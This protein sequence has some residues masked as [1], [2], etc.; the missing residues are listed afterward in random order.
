MRFHSVSIGFLSVFAAAAPLAAQSRGE[1]L[2][3]RLEIDR[4][5]GE[6]E[7]RRTV[8][9]SFVNNT[10]TR[11]VFFLAMHQQD[12]DWTPLNSDP[13]TTRV[14]FVPRKVGTY[15]L[16][17][18]ISDGDNWLQRTITFKALDIDAEF[19]MHLMADNAKTHHD[20]PVTLTVVAN[21]RLLGRRITFLYFD[22]TAA[23]WQAIEGTGNR[24]TCRWTPPRP[25]QYRLRVDVSSPRPRHYWSKVIDYTAMTD[26]QYN[27]RPVVTRVRMRGEPTIPFP[28]M[29][30]DL[31]NPPPTVVMPDPAEGR[32]LEPQTIRLNLG[33][34]RSQPDG[35]T[36]LL[37]Q[38]VDDGQWQVLSSHL[39]WRTTEFTWVP[40]RPG[41]YRVRVDVV[42]PGH[43]EDR[44]F[45]EF[46]ARP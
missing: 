7:D 45:G 10:R 8:S 36:T 16:R 35:R 12:R 13:A 1:T 23:R 6:I 33:Q 26:E 34:A 2:A 19:R 39:Y 40:T 21:K 31:P 28:G 37:V 38:N 11:Q 18:R 17:V 43:R 14:R 32:I 24:A 20:R 44:F 4:P 30:V 5:E 22:P 42:R 3:Y 46:T 15:M 27:E 9:V 29:Q 25:G 41:R